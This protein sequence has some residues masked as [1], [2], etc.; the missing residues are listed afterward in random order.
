MPTLTPLGIAP[1]C[2]IGATPAEYVAAAASAGFD[3]V[4]IRLSP[5]TEADTVYT[6]LGPD[7]RE[8]EL[9]IADSGLDVLDTEVFR[10]TEHATA[11]LWMPL[12]EMSARLGARLFNVVGADSDL[13]RL[14]DRVGSLTFDA[15]PFGITP[16]LEPLAYLP[17]NSYRTA[18]D[19]ALKAG[20]AVE[21]DGLHAVR[22]GLDPLLVADHPELFPVFQ[23]CDAPAVLVEWGEDRP[24]GARPGDSDMVIES[25]LNRLLPG[26]GDSP[27]GELMAALR[28]GTPVA[29]E[30]PNLELQARLSVDE[31]IELLHREAVEFV[32]RFSTSV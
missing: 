31:Y 4:G 1:L 17:L 8:L 16:V 11:E 23:V 10:M 27:L 25:R 21:L 2:A 6:P 3:F 26:R 19:I 32:G 18:V 22:T 12:L 29:M 15:A 5:V 9:L 28:P 7:F 20:C 30:V 13:A 14:A 24:P